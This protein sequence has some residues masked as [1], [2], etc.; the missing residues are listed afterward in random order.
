MN[1]K[2]YAAIDIGSNAMRL[3]INNVIERDGEIH[4]KKVDITRVPIR[5]GTEAFLD[6]KI[7]EKTIAKLMNAM[8][9]FSHLMKVHDVEKY[10]ACATS[11]MRETSNGAEIIQRI[12]AETAIDIEVI[13]G[14]EEAQI[15]YAT[16]IENLI[17]KPFNFLYVDV[18]G[19][20]VEFSFF[21]HGELIASKSFDIGT[22]RILNHLVSQAQWD[23][24]KDWLEK[25][26]SN[27]K[28]YLIGSGG[29][30]NKVFKLSRK[31]FTEALTLEYIEDYL[32]LLKKHSYED[33]VIK[34]DLNLDRADVIIPALMIFTQVMKWANATEIFVP[35]IGLADGIIKLIK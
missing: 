34:L 15:I 6:K 9:A 11:A 26:V 33:R 20:S 25:I 29:N 1:I 8:E 13:S 23:E 17:N 7:S 4:Y 18:G 35:K 10:R 21:A 30:I 5:L 27:K 28:V 3:L 12:K 22:I 24:L 14:D 16:H 31:P 32:D 2:K 19:G